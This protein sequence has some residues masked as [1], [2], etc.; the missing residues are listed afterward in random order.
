MYQ[1]YS[2]ASIAAKSCSMV[3]ALI[4]VGPYVCEFCNSVGIHK[5]RITQTFLF[6]LYPS[7][8]Q[9]HCINN[10]AAIHEI[11]IFQMTKGKIF[12]INY[13]L[14]TLIFCLLL[15]TFK[16]LLTISTSCWIMYVYY[17]LHGVYLW[18]PLA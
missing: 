2:L 5:N 7:S 17:Y 8:I 12:I 16:L 9:V 13:S 18:M 14:V 4:F 1:G 6:V 11:I 10:E 3:Y 15:F